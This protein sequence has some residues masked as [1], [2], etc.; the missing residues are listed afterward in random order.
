VLFTKDPFTLRTPVNLSSDQRTRILLFA[1]NLSLLPG[2][3][4]ASVTVLGTDS[5]GFT[6]NMA[7]EEVRPFAGLDWVTV[8]TV[9]LPDDTTIVGD[10]SVNA[11]LRGVFSNSVF[12]GIKGP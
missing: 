4:P 12:V 8:L 2:E 1:A 7:V 9:R 3:T 6:Y 10:L 5:R 11:A